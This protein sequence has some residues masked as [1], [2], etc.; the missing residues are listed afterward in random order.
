MRDRISFSELG[1]YDECNHHWYLDY[2]VGNYSERFGIHLDFGTAVHSAIEKYKTR[3]DQVSVTEA[4]K[5]FQETFHSLWEK[6]NLKYTERD[7][8]NDPEEF[9]KAGT[10]IIEKF[11]ECPELAAC[12][13]IHNELLISEPIDRI[14]GIEIKFRGYVDLVVK[15]KDGRGKDVIYI[16]DF[17]GCSWGWTGEQRSDEKKQ[18]QLLLYKHFFC[19][20][21]DLDPEYVRCAF[22]LLKRR[23]PKG[24]CP[25]EFFK[26]SAGPKS[27]QRALD[28]MN[29]DITQMRGQLTEL[30][31]GK[32]STLPQ[33][34]Q[35]CVNPFGQVCP[36]A[37]TPS[38][39]GS[40]RP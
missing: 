14:D 18:R 13:P 40:K 22:V 2:V 15:G 17:K 27:V 24:A 21:Y 38:C 28:A 3:K 23:P 8:K 11:H 29:S 30:A 4:I 10:N 33:N 19:K 35:A 16:C 32:C 31:L 20:K 12:E 26:I 25:V 6:N 39:P 37:G 7:R 5:I 34:F 1:L 9:I 36:Y